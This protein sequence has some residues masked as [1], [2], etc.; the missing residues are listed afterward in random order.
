LVKTYS[1]LYMDARRALLPTEGADMASQMARTL[2]CHVSGKTHEQILAGRDLYASEA[3]DDA[4]AQAATEA[5]MDGLLFTGK[6]DKP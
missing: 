2:L 4:M 1:Q 3:I 6:C 5:C